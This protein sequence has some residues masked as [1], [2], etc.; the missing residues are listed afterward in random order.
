MKHRHSFCCVW[1][2]LLFWQSSCNTG[3]IRD[4]DLINQQFQITY[5]VDSTRG[6]DSTQLATLQTSKAIYTFSKKGEGNRHILMGMLSKDTP[7]SWSLKKDSLLIDQTAYH[8]K[9]EG[10]RLVLRSDSAKIIL[11]KQP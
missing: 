3:S 9:K 6:L 8:I 7:F 1:A 4:L 5:N 10:Q 2:L 11:S